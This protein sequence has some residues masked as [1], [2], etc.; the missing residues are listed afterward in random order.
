MTGLEEAKVEIG[1]K[2]GDLI[3]RWE[4][5]VFCTMRIKRSAG[6]DI[7]F[8]GRINKASQMLVCGEGR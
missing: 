1:D 6:I 5:T 7:Y 8:R 3:I 4:I 2:A